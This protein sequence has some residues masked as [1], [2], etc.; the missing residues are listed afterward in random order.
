V[1]HAPADGFGQFVID[2]AC[3]RDLRLVCG[4]LN[5]E[6][7]AGRHFPSDACSSEIAA[8]G[9]TQGH[10]RGSQAYVFSGYGCALVTDGQ[11]IRFRPPDLTTPSP[12]VQITLSSTIELPVNNEDACRE[13]ATRQ[14]IEKRNTLTFPRLLL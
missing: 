8:A 3:R 11:P 14:F 9:T 5:A 13:S 6:S 4:S 12:S 2:N 10:T 1:L 7:R